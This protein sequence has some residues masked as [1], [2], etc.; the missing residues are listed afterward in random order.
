[1]D[2][3]SHNS[4]KV[5]TSMADEASEILLIQQAQAD[6]QN[7][8]YLYPRYVQRVYSYIAYKVGRQQDVEDLVSET[9]MRALENI[10]HFE[11][12]G[13]SSFRAWLMGIAHNIVR[14]FY[15]QNNLAEVSI[16]DLPL[17]QDLN[18]D[19][20]LIQQEKFKQVYEILQ[21]ISPRR[22]EII[23][24]KYYGGLR[25]HEIA[26]VLGIEERTVSSHLSRALAEIQAKYDLQAVKDLG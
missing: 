15:R 12:R 1:M 17:S 10:K 16:D 9:F 19:E 24:L 3:R 7:F 22:R 26:E 11:Y 8:R 18:L 4:R 23:L 14:E 2:K 5:D 21:T 6:P 20:R 25:N 13:D